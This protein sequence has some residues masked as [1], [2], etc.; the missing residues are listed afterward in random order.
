MRIFTIADVPPELANQWLQHLRDIEIAH[1]GCHFEVMTDAPEH[2][3]GEM[4]DMI[5][6]DPELTFAAILLTG[7]GK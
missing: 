2:S 5:R 7:A 1:P 4:I 3:L 6:V